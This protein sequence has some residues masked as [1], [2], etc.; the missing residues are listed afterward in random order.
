MPEEKTF[1]KIPLQSNDGTVIVVDYDVATRSALLS[2]ML[3]DLKGMGINE[4]GPVP[5]PN[6]C[7]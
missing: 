3:D 2:T 4:L 6:V 7:L 5:L 1:D